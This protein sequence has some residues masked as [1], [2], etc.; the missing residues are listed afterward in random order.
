MRMGISSAV[1]HAPCD[2]FGDQ[3]DDGGDAGGDGAES[4]DEHAQAGCGAAMLHPVHDHAGLREREG[5]ESADGVERDEAV[6]D[7]AEEDEQGRR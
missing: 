1:T 7:A 5:H 3:H 2:E 6:G 4:V